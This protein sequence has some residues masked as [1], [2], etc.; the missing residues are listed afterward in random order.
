[1][2]EDRLEDIKQNF[3]IHYYFDDNSHSMN[4][5]VRNAMEK[6]LL[7]LISEVGR[8]LNINMQI[9]SEV[10]KEGG[11]IDA[12]NLTIVLSVGSAVAIYFRT[13][14]NQ[15]ITYYLTGGFY[16]NKDTILNNALKEEELKR[17]KI[18]TEK[19]ELESRILKEYNAL[20]A[21]HKL[22]RNISNFYKKAKNYEKIK[23]IGYQFN[24]SNELCIERNQFKSFIIDG[25]K[26]IEVVEDADIEIISPVLKEGKYKWR[27]IYNGEK[28]DFSMGDSGFKNAVIGQEYN[29]INGT[30]INCQLEIS[31][32]FDDYG[33]EI[34]T[35]YRVKKVYGIKTNDIITTTKF[36]QKRRKQKEESLEPTLFDFAKDSK[37]QQ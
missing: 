2:E 21:N 3:Q 5:F 15:I 4:A 13:S 24:N 7:K 27:G 9:N 17:S 28:I 31:R 25:N 10:K 34:K 22:N 37:E 23:K 35:L 18:Q 32:T 33:E 16:K 30:T 12:F 26:D 14:I 8:T 36:G 6:D 19:A 20:E 1:M 29:F 11:L